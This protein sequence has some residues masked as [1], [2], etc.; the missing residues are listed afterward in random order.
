MCGFRPALLALLL[1]LYPSRAPAEILDNSFFVEEA[2]NQERGVVQH[3]QTLHWTWDRQAGRT[4]RAFS[5]GLTQE[6]PVGG[7]RHQLSYTIPYMRMFG[8]QPRAGGIGDIQVHYRLQAIE[9][10]ATRPAV[11]PRLTVYVPTGD[12]ARGLGTGTAGLEMNVP[13]SKKVGA[14]HLHLNAG[15]TWFPDAQVTL[16]GG[17]KSPARDLFGTNLGLS[18]ILI[19]S[20]RLNLLLEFTAR[21]EESIADSGERERSVRVLGSPGLRYSIDRRDGGQWVLGA[22]LPVGLRDAEDDVGALLYLSFEH[23]F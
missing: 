3:I 10:D 17:A 8:D 22:A 9:E 16:V 4:A 21:A 7:V 18:S 15:A 11:A 13:V 20:N 19:V 12:A 23:P 5:Y 2:Y 1:F 6:W 14:F